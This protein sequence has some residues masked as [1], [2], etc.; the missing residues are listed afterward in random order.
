MNPKKVEAYRKSEEVLLK[1]Y[2]LERHEYFIPVKG[3]NLKVR[4]QEIG[5]G[6]PILFI[7]GGPN[8]GSTWL[9]LASLL[10]GTRR[11]VLDRPGCGLSDGIFYRNMTLKG[12]EQ[13]IVCAIDSVLSYFKLE[14]TTL[15]G[16]S[17]GGYWAIKYALDTPEKVKNI[18]LE[19]APALVEGSTLPNFMKSIGNPFLKWLIPKLPISVSNSEKT[20]KE[21][22]HSHSIDNKLI[23]DFFMEWYVSLCNNTDTMKY[24]FDVISKVL[25]GGRQNPQFILWD[26]EIGQLN[27]RSLWLWGKDDAFA[28]SEV[29][30]RIHRKVKGSK[31]VEFDNAG[32]LPWLDHP[33]EHA[34]LI[35]E[36]MTDSYPERKSKIASLKKAGSSTVD[37]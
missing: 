16:S 35:N 2:N 19:G 9:E 31:L 34:R 37:V 8:A 10:P 20:L 12:L 33:E 28:G 23:D 29:A 36:F 11:L 1:Q 13:L 22:G 3:F 26:S 30:R 5:S 17:F 6:P 18:I 4:V 7:H 15:L 14:K 25:K 21:I 32:H 24:E 27:V